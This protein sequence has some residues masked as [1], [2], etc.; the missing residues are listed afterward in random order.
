MA[1]KERPAEL[2]DIG[3]EGRKVLVGRVFC[4]FLVYFACFFFKHFVQ[5]VFCFKGFL[6]QNKLPSSDQLLICSRTSLKERTMQ[7]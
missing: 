1:V 4:M 2:R 5:N 6:K 3:L 7:A